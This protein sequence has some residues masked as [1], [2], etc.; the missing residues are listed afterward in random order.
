M[1]GHTALIESS[2]DGEGAEMSGMTELTGTV[3]NVLGHSVAV[4][5][6][7]EPW[8][9]DHAIHVTVS[10]FAP[11]ALYR[12]SGMA[13]TGEKGLKCGGDM[14]V[15]RI[16]RRRWPRRRM[17]LPVTLCPVEGVSR[18]EGLPG[19]TVDLSVG[20]TCV[21][22]LRPVGGEGDPMLI[23]RL[24]DGSTVVCSTTTVAVEE[25]ADGW[26]YRLA[27][28]GL[29]VSDVERLESLTAIDE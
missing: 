27:F 5:C 3:E 24:P 23:L 4:L 26:R 28:R 25:L 1:L 15:E 8:A 14:T 17:D 10:V 13:L 6:D 7:D 18:L 20:G 29:D 22:T 21:E 12:L 9:A 11:D 16:Q 19:R 2:I